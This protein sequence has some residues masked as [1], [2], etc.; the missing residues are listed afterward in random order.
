MGCP[1][2]QVYHRHGA[3]MREIWA[4]FAV[5]SVVLFTRAG[6][7]LRTVGWRGLQGDDYMAIVVWLCLI[8][9]SV[10]VTVVYRFGSNVD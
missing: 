7:R 10:T 3:Y 4:W 2:T 9:D 6:V 8:C 5:G 1:S